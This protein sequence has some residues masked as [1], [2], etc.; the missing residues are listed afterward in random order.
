MSHQHRK[1]SESIRTAH[2]LKQILISE[3]KN[4]EY[5]RGVYNGFELIS[6]ILLGVEAKIILKE[7]EAIESEELK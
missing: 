7:S 6:S 1:L 4:S 3:A 5:S 2:Y